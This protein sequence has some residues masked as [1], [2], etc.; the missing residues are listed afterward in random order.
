MKTINS[1]EYNHTVDNYS[2]KISDYNLKLESEILYVTYKVTNKIIFTIL[3]VTDFVKAFS[4]VKCLINSNSPSFRS[5]YSMSELKS[6][7]RDNKKS[8][9][10][11]KPKVELPI[12][13]LFLCLFLMYL[14]P[15][16][17]KLVL[18][19]F[20]KVYFLFKV[21]LNEIISIIT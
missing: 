18:S 13:M 15:D 14:S 5:Y 1:K 11:K 2:T 8:K 12:S 6:L 4:Y 16:L 3:D 19:V 21:H 20:V 9:F 17:R 10:E 7:F